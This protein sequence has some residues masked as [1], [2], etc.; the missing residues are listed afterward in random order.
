MAAPPQIV[1]I[2]STQYP[3]FKLIVFTEV[4]PPA[5]NFVQC[6]NV[7]VPSLDALLVTS[8]TR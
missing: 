7:T 3:S 8:L 1:Q 2:N 4:Y 5:P 6:P